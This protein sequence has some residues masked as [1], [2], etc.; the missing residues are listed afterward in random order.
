MVQVTDSVTR[1]RNMIN[2][3]HSYYSESTRS[4]N[5]YKFFRALA[6]VLTDVEEETLLTIKD[7][8]IDEAREEALTRIFGSLFSLK[9][10]SQLG[11]D[12]D[13]F[14]WVLKM[15]LW[16][17]GSKGATLE[18]LYYTVRAITGVSPKVVEHY[19]YAGWLLGAHTL[20]AGVVVRTGSKPWDWISTL[21]APLNAIFARTSTNIWVVG[22]NFIGESENGGVDFIDR[23]P[24]MSADWIDITASGNFVWVISSSELYHRVPSGWDS[25]FTAPSGQF[26]SLKSLNPLQVFVASDNGSIYYSADGGFSWSTLVTSTTVIQDM[27]VWESNQ[28]VAVGSNGQALRVNAFTTTE[29]ALPGA[30]TL[31]GVATKTSDRN[32]MVAVGVA[33]SIFRSEDGGVSWSPAVSG[34]TNDL[35]KVAFANDSFYV[36]GEGGIILKST[37][38][39]LTWEAE[40]HNGPSSVD[41]TDISFS[42]GAIGFVVADTSQI[43]RRNGQSPGY[44]LADGETKANGDLLDANFLESKKGRVNTIDVHV[45]KDTDR[46]DL[47]QRFLYAVVPAHIVINYIP[48]S[49]IGTDVYYGTDEYEYLG[50]SG[51]NV[52]IDWANAG[53]PTFVN[54]RNYRDSLTMLRIYREDDLPIPQL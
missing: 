11:W 17:F 7:L 48:E 53:D 54:G 14:R 21:S 50:S 22:S 6:D 47:V 27:D 37:D 1:R 45:W 20:G 39:G 13:D 9:R 35:H 25:Q 23:T 51:Q 19:K 28:L 8:G 26:T 16:A 52:I 33:G 5:Y 15:L 44:T 36:V 42:G 34:T 32:V 30:P 40:E 46:R 18:G 3:L 43:L 31:T 49:L 38:D 10:Q 41:L 24:T 2:L 4:T 29:V 12:W